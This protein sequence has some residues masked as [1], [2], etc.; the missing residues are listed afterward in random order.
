MFRVPID[1][2]RSLSA[3]AM[4]PGG[5]RASSVMSST[6]LLCL[7]SSNLLTPTILLAMLDM[8]ESTECLG[9]IIHALTHFYAL[10]S[11]AAGI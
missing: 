3:G 11:H 2:M 4:L 9:L 8:L 6:R 1:L 10:A 7:H 5:D